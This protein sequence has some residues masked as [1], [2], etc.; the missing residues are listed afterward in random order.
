MTDK[1][2]FVDY[3]DEKICVELTPNFEK[4]RKFVIC[5]HGGPGGTK[6]G[7]SDL[8][9]NS[10]TAL[11]ANGYSIVRFDMLGT[12][13]STG[14]Y[15]YMTVK[16]QSKQFRAVIDFLKGMELGE[17]SIIAESMGATVALMNWPQDAKR[18]ALLWPAI[19]LMDTD[20]VEYL[21]EDHSSN[22]QKNGF[23]LEGDIQIG[24]DF[25]QEFQSMGALYEK[26]SSVNCPLLFVHGDSDSSVPHEQSQKAHAAYGGDKKLIIVPGGDHCLRDQQSDVVSYLSAWFK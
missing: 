11:S 5:V 17:M 22:I 21:D 18:G 3:G 26:L 13:D 20:L 10:R 24:K 15:R 8:F 2:F 7:P 25:V 23:T 6:E 19:D 9:L 16:D 1:R 14:N 12:G 4:G